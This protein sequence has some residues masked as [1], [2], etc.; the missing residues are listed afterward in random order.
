MVAVVLLAYLWN[1]DAGPEELQVLP[2]LLG[3]E[4]GVEDGQ[5]GEHAHVSALQSQGGLQHVVDELLQFIGVDDDVQ[6]THLGKTELFPI[7]T[8][9][10]HLE[11][12]KS[13][14]AF[15]KRR[16]DSTL[17]TVRVLLALRAPSTAAW[18]S[19]R[20]TSVEA[21]RPNLSHLHVRRGVIRLD[22][23]VNGFF[24]QA[25]LKL[26]L[27]QLTPHR[28]QFICGELPSN[29]QNQVLNHILSTI[30]IQ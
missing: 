17:I 9:K 13:N 29:H 15:N 12:N 10:A 14:K 18:Y 26:G 20:C 7:Y 22:V 5:L 6:P 1:V 19:P 3:L 11:E 8:R 27:R 25:L 23:R 21:R 16:V 4:F 30:H 2:H 28:H 24:D